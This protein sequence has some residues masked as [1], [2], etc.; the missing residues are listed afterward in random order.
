M[1]FVTDSSLQDE[2][3]SASVYRTLPV[4]VS[5]TFLLQAS[6]RQAVAALS[7][8]LRPRLVFRDALIER[9]ELGIG[10]GAE[11][12]YFQTDS[13]V[14]IPVIPQNFGLFLYL[15]RTNPLI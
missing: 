7:P 11:I 4:Y 3:S 6:V 10:G 13:V 2:E 5:S 14:S 1:L 9:G 15:S 12:D 8:R